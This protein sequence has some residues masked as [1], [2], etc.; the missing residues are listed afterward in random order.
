MLNIVVEAENGKAVA[1]TQKL[2]DAVQT[3]TYRSGKTSAKMLNDNIMPFRLSFAMEDFHPFYDE[4][5]YQIQ[6]FIESGRSRFHRNIRNLLYD[7]EVPALVL[8]MADLGI[9]F[10]VCLIPLSLGVIA[11]IAEIVAAKVMFLARTMKDVLTE[12]LVVVIFLDCGHYRI[13]FFR[14]KRHEC[15]FNKTR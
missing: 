3:K 10:I 14:L 1:A 7:E 6:R 2:I 13:I 15:L 12:M 4:F 11:F 8:S 9:G 5:H